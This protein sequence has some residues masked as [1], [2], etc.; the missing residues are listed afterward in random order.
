MKALLRSI[1]PAEFYER[2]EYFRAFALGMVYTFFL[3]AQ[4]FT[5]EKFPG[6]IE[7]YQIKLP[8]LLVAVLLTVFEGASLPFLLS[9]SLPR[10]A[11]TLSRLSV[12]IASFS[13]LVLATVISARGYTGNAG[14]FGGTLESSNGW[15]FVGFMGLVALSA[16]L[17]VWELP[18]APTHGKKKA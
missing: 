6:V 16:V 5:F 4:L 9:M 15:W 14:I 2:P 12:L 3:I 1:F 11:R 17:V 18:P 7:A 10:V 13:W 8:G